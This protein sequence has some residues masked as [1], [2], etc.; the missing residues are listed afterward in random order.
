M[1][2]SLSMSLFVFSGL[3]LVP[4]FE[5]AK[6]PLQHVRPPPEVPSLSA[7]ACQPCHAAQYNQ[8]RASRH[9]QS[10]TNRIFKVSFRHEPL[11]WCVYCHAPLPSQAEAILNKRLDSVQNPTLVSEGVN[12]ATC[13][14]RSGVILSAR[15][16]SAAAET[17]HAIAYRPELATA[18]LCAGCHQFNFSYPGH[19]VRYTREPMQNTWTEWKTARS[20]KPCQA[21]HMKQGAH[22]FPG[23]H[24]LQFLRSA[25]SVQVVR[26]PS[27][28]LE[29]RVFGH[30]AD[31]RLPTGDPFR[32]LIL[33]LWSGTEQTKPLARIVYGRGFRGGPTA[34][35][36][37]LDQ[38]STLPVRDGE[39]A[40]EQR[41]VLTR[42]PELDTARS[43]QLHYY[44]AAPGT[45]R[46][47]RPE[48]IST[49][50][51]AGRITDAAQPDG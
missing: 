29:V 38:D 33:T 14:I 28:D 47:L 1:P 8:W 36:W 18:G 24:D 15:P 16:P 49:Q 6:R 27:G 11:P 12:C 26:Q 3:L 48:D 41:T 25:F 42:S 30:N 50:V 4:L 46:E 39:K 21:C 20:P 22:D 51:S 31:H 43:F 7:K 32:R 44:Y 10:F 23:A 13:H 40:S 5:Q 17:A 19:P 2:L 9:A 45:H 34:N 37:I 35:T